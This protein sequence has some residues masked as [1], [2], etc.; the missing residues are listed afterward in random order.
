[1]TK[2]PIYLTLKVLYLSPQLGRMGN[3][4]DITLLKNSILSE[5]LKEPLHV[6]K[7]SE[8][9]YKVIHG[10][11]CFLAMSALAEAGFNSRF[12]QIPCLVVDG[13]EEEDALTLLACN[14][15]HVPMSEEEIDERVREVATVLE[16]DAIAR[17]SGLSLD[18]VLRALSPGFGD[19]L[20]APA[21][22]EPL[23]IDEAN[24]DVLRAALTL[25]KTDEATR[26]TIDT[27]LSHVYRYLN[28]KSVADRTLLNLAKAISAHGQKI[29][30][31]DEVKTEATAS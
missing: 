28:G 13:P 20:R 24:M 4:G 3:Q 26:R 10:R 25:M 29:G 1:M 19:L 12:P 5:G 31:S 23:V 21:E 11:R 8:T 18:R 15:L 7:M 6:R 14:S 27:F 2:R 22:E 17:R 30:V 9:H 16:P